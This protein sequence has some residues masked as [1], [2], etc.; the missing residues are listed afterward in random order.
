MSTRDG[1]NN[2]CRR[3]TLNSWKHNYRL[4]DDV[5]IRQCSRESSRCVWLYAMDAYSG[6]MVGACPSQNFGWK[7]KPSNNCDPCKAIG[8]EFGFIEIRYGGGG[9]KWRR[10]HKV[11]KAW[12]L[13]ILS[14][15]W[16]RI[17]WSSLAGFGNDDKYILFSSWRFCF[18]RTFL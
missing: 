7:V 18:W 10:Q 17:L 8:F 2:P 12:W 14:R 1:N 5:H 15:R 13:L 11:A 4:C 16:K 9:L 6:L 3:L